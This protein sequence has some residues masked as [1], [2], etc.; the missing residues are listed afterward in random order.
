MI[1]PEIQVLAFITAHKDADELVMDAVT[2]LPVK[3]VYTRDGMP[4]TYSYIEY[5]D[6]LTHIEEVATTPH[7]TGS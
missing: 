5:F 4:R 2:G 6:T 7:G 1:A 3:A